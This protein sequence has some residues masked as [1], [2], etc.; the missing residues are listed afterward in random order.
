M[1]AAMVVL[2]ITDVPDLPPDVE[3]EIGALAAVDDL[4]GAR[5]N[6]RQCAETSPAVATAS[7]RLRRRLLPTKTT[8]VSH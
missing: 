4:S 2:R 7:M 1:C 8:G 6:G 5:K 3:A